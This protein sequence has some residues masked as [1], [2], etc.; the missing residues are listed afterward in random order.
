MFALRAR[1]TCPS[2]S[3]DPGIYDE[4]P[5]LAAIGPR[6]SRRAAGHRN[7]AGFPGSNDQLEG[8][9]SSIGKQEG[10]VIISEG[11]PN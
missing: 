8:V 1:C 9:V 6:R 11:T 2:R 3:P 7:H 5:G 4:V 10:A